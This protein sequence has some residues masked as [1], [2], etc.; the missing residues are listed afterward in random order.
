MS[1]FLMYTFSLGAISQSWLTA[2]YTFGVG[3]VLCC[4]LLVS[5]TLKLKVSLMQLYFSSKEEMKVCLEL[6]LENERPR[7]QIFPKNYRAYFFV[8]V[9]NTA[10]LAYKT[11]QCK[12]I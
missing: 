7:G 11:C 8:S 4:F 9:E 5:S 3:Q 10:G 2:S 12:R 6:V 1:K